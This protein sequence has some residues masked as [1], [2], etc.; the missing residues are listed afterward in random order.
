MRVSGHGLRD[1]GKPFELVAGRLRRVWVHEGLGVCACGASSA[2]LQTD[3]ARRR[4][5]NAHK[6]E[7]A[8]DG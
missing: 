7:V 4:W 2:S 3:A 5:H 6:R 1:E 8:Q